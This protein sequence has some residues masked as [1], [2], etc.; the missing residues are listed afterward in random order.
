[1]IQPYF[2]AL[3]DAVSQFQYQFQESPDGEF[4][5]PWLQKYGLVKYGSVIV[6]HVPDPPVQLPEIY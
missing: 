6:G 3:H 4:A 5:E 2:C 1:M